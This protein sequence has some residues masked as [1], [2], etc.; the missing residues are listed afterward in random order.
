MDPNSPDYT[1][2]DEFDEVPDTIEYDPRD[3]PFMQEDCIDMLL[4]R[5]DEYKENL[6]KFQGKEPGSIQILKKEDNKDKEREE[7]IKN[8]VNT[9]PPSYPYI[10]NIPYINYSEGSLA[11]MW[12][13]KKGKPKYDQK[14][15]NSWLG[16]YIIKKKSEKEK[17]YL[18]ALDGRKMPLPVDGSLLRPYIQIT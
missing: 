4:P 7:A 2:E 10:E 18:T 9:G 12:D 3:L 14:D 16:P 15:D 17:Y 6:A 8:A 5:T 1:S 11:F 13:K